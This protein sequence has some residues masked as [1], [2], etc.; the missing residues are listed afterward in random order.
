MTSNSS[1]RFEIAATTPEHVAFIA[2][3]LRQRDCDEIWSAVGTDPRTALE[4]SIALSSIHRTILLDG[5]PAA[6]FGAAPSNEDNCGVAWLLGTDAID[7]HARAFWLASREGLALLFT[8]FA[9]LFNYVDA[10]NQTSLRWL[11]RLGAEVAAPVPF[12]VEARPFHY[13]ELTR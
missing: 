11:K 5:E 4:E 8:W 6:I 2:P 3:R 12:G 7:T 10:R 13:F 1:R 9:R